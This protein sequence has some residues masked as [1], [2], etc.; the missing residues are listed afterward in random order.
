MN[1]MSRR[2]FV[3]A[4]ILAGTLAIPTV[5]MADEKSPSSPMDKSASSDTGEYD[6]SFLDGMSDDEL[7]ALRDE[8]ANRL[9]SAQTSP[10]TTSGDDSAETGDQDGSSTIEEVPV[11]WN[12]PIETD[13]YA[14]T[15][16]GSEWASTIDPPNTSGF[17]NHVVD[18]EGTT[19]L[20]IRG[21]LENRSNRTIN[22]ENGTAFQVK[23]NNEYDFA[24][25]AIMAK[26]GS[27]NFFSSENSPM[28]LETIN[29][30]LFA[31]ITD[32]VIEQCQSIKCEW[33]FGK[34]LN[35]SLTNYDDVK[36]RYIIAW[37]I[38]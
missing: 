22:I 1:S 7:K 13:E 12:T 4:S 24:G 31:E 18:Q 25:H 28:P 21:T 6:F 19:Y 15:L 38:E 20:L 5:A 32:K 29:I 17:F 36:T 30:Y 10:M 34:D 16:Y 33:L 2:N 27:N 8:L 3:R 14:F 37:D 26:D 35:G 9:G 23:I 11:Y